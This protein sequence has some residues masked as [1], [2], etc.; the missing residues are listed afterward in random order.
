MCFLFFNL[1]INRERSLWRALCVFKDGPLKARR[2]TLFVAIVLA[3]EL[4]DSCSVERVNCEE[5]DVEDEGG[6][7][8]MNDRGCV[9]TDRSAS[10]ERCE[11]T[12][13][14]RE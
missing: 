13:V 2:P 4:D 3:M 12:R 6:E 8:C 7:V 1:A 14:R 5:I 11:D 10:I 9:C